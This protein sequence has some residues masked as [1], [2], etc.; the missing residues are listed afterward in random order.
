V[1]QA[2]RVR[3]AKSG[4]LDIAYRVSGQG[5]LDLLFV[6]A[7]TGLLEMWW[8]GPFRGF[9]SRLE[10]S[11][12]LI[13]LEKRGMGLSD[14]VSGAAT[15]EDR[16][17]DVR[18]VLDAAGSERAALL[19]AS[20]G[21]PVTC[22]FAATYPARVVALVLLGAVA[23]WAWS[24]DCPWAFT[25]DDNQ[26]YRDYVEG[27]WGSGAAVEVF[28]P[29]LADDTEFRQQVA[30]YE[31]MAGTPAAALALLE[32]NTL[33]D[34]RAALPAISAPTLV[35]HRTAD[36]A[37][38][39]EH[40]RCLAAHIPGAR[41]VELPG[42]DHWPVGDVDDVVGEIEEFLTGTRHV[43]EP[44]RVLTTVLFTDIVDS[45]GRAAAL[46]DRKWRAL[47]DEHDERVRVQLDRFTGREI[48]TT[49]D[50]FVASFDGPARAIRCARAVIDDVRGLGLDVRA[51]IHTGECEVR[52]R[53]LAGVAVHLAAR[54]AAHAEPGQV[55]VSG[56]VPP[57]VV[58]AGI[59]FAD[60]GEHDLKGV[61]GP[62]RLWGVTAAG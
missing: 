35:L 37:V 24:P 26:Q 42:D 54:V 4:E 7:G 60:L 5:P 22:L 10:Q 44:E 14:R 47:L 32:M 30:R 50:G 49:G 8:E 21:G 27:Y 34:V 51:G 38:P 20:E 25:E 40:G 3:Y 59:E 39:V 2:P 12:R 46:G 43:A 6:P 1:G 45:T 61:P 41:L 16:M 18:A 29:S 17:D 11:F 36:R 58:G 56:S 48:N 13:T 62:W 28:A 15:L 19:G 31:R 23:K 9:R 57:L 33:I 53:D 55:V 52:G